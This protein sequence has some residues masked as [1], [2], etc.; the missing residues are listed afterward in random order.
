MSTIKVQLTVEVPAGDYCCCWAFMGEACHWLQD[1]HEPGVQP[2]EPRIGKL[3]GRPRCRLR[4]G[5]LEWD[6]EGVEK[7]DECV[8][9]PLV[10]D[11]G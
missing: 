9:L 2:P 6:E 7:A 4:L 1:W 5:A 3:W 10:K 8:V 11:D